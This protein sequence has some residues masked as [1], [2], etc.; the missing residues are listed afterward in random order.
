MNV[1]TT[2]VVLTPASPLPS[3]TIT[4]TVSNVADLAG[5]KMAA[6]YTWSFSTACGGGGGSGGGTSTQ[7]I[8]PLFGNGNNVGQVTVDTAGNFTVQLHGATANESLTAEFCAA[9]F[10]TATAPNC[11][12]IGSL[13]TD[14][15]GDASLK[16]KFPKPGSWAGDFELNNG[17]TNA[18]GLGAAYDTNY[19]PGYMSTLVAGPI[20]TGASGS[21]NGTISYSSSPA[22][23]GSL[24]FTITGGQA[25]TPYGAFERD[26]YVDT[27]SYSL[28]NSQ[29][30]GFFTTD[31]AG[32]VTFTV[33]P[34][35][36]G[37]DIFGVLRKSPTGDI[38]DY[39]G[40]FV[41]PQ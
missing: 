12:S 28:Q 18:P 11:F 40:G 13:S 22:P 9:A 7:Y 36:P 37:G 27:N 24:T 1:S 29:G 34:H 38:Q 33:L 19:G 3:G 21:A 15:S 4:V 14:G 5:V 6:P 2:Q 8:A 17:P 26:L 25:S 20:N 32:N 23:N 35:V 31:S 39:T 41:V 16:A 30:Q 10:G